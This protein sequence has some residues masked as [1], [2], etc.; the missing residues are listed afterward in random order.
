[1]KTMVMKKV[2]IK[3]VVWPRDLEAD[4]NMVTLITADST[5]LSNELVV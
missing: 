3:K 4:S 1:M 5:N 2:I